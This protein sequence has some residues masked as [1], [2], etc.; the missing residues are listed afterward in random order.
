MP[1]KFS[2]LFFMGSAVTAWAQFGPVGGT[3]F[4]II[5]ATAF[6]GSRNRWVQYIVTGLVIVTVGLPAVI[7]AGFLWVIVWVFCNLTGQ[8]EASRDLSSRHEDNIIEGDF[9]EVR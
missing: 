7:I 9:V 6:I 5:L 8:L 1:V 3:L 2:T 4:I